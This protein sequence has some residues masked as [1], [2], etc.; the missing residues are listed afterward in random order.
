MVVAI[1]LLLLLIGGLVFFI[2]KISTYKELVREKET[3]RTML[4]YELNDLMAEHDSIKREYGT[5]AD[6]LR[7][8]DSIIRANAEEIKQLL[9]YK[10]EYTRV[11]KKLNL[12]R[13][14]TQGYVHQLDSLYT[15]N[16]EL[17]EENEKIRQQYAREQ[18]RTRELSKEK[19]TLVEKVNEAAVLRAYNLNVTTVRFTG[20]GRE[21][22]TDKANKVERVKIC[23]TVGANNLVEPGIKAFYTRIIRP[24]G[25]VVTQ[26]AGGD[27]SFE[28]DGKQME[29]T[30]K[31]EINYKQE[32]TEL[33]MWWDKKSKEEAAMVGVYNVFVYFDGKE[34]GRSSFE[35]R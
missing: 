4:Q 22:L 30:V 9:N 3:Q 33:C 13:K 8:K 14:I 16:R 21:R 18:D 17:K 35:L 7:V 28:A 11:N 1:I 34:V 6:S 12:L 20:S 15:V 25:V 24:D 19:E 2:P 29:Y 10:W 31:K 23:F 26:K 27:Y 32:S 5:L